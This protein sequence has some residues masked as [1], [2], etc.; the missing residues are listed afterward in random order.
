M[1]TLL[2]RFAGTTCPVVPGVRL[3]VNPAFRIDHGHVPVLLEMVEGTFGRIDRNMREVGAAEPFELRIEVRK[4]APLQQRIIRKV[5]P[6]HD[7]QRAKGDLLGLREEIVD[8]AIK[9]ESANAPNSTSSSGIILVASSTSKSNR[10]AN[11]SSKSCK[12]SSHSG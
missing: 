10:S 11:S 7:V 5:D 8:T 6:W 9:H 3:I 1:K 2:G 4:V 12:P